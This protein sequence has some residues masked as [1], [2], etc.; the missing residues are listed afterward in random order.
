MSAFFFILFT[1]EIR[2]HLHVKDKFFWDLLTKIY[3]ELHKTFIYLET[4]KISEISQFQLSLLFP[5]L[6]MPTHLPLVSLLTQ[7]YEWLLCDK[8]FWLSFTHCFNY[9]V[10]MWGY[11]PITQ[12]RRLDNKLNKSDKIFESLFIPKDFILNMTLR[13]LFRLFLFMRVFKYYN[14]KHNV[15]CNRFFGTKVRHN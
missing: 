6:L 10:E 3:A 7:C 15:H 11:P 4:N 1:S 12:L 13:K 9:G 2:V 8:R 5:N 14:V